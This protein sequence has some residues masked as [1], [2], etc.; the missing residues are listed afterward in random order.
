MSKFSREIE[1]LYLDV[2]QAGFKVEDTIAHGVN[3]KVKDDMPGGSHH[4][5]GTEADD[6][7]QAY[8][9]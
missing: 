2:I 6:I 8:L 5:I 4:S 7:S 1:Y 9:L 3:A